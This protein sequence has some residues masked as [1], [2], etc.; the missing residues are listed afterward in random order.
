M[1]YL[2]KQEYQGLALTTIDDNQFDKLERRA[3]LA[4]DQ[5]TMR[6]YRRSDLEHDTDWRRDAFKYAV[7]LQVEYIARI[8]ALTLED[9]RAAGRITSQ[10]IGGTSVSL[11]GSSTESETSRTAVCDDARAALSGTGL[12]YRGIHYAD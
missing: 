6:H 1:A 10:T 7:A 3:E 8:G 4:L 12:L 11:G 5:L 9:Q 2:T